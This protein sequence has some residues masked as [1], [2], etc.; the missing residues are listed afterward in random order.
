[1]T[2][3]EKCHNKIHKTTTKGSKRVKTTKGQIIEEI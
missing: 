2:L 3:C 1:M